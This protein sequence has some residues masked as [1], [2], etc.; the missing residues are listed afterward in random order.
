MTM[1]TNPTWH[2]GGYLVACGSKS[3]AVNVWDIRYVRMQVPQSLPAHQNRILRCAFHPIDDCL[4]T[5]STDGKLGFST[6]LRT[7]VRDAAAL[8]PL[9]H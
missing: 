3:P 9:H 1:Y 2:P 4:T 6:F 7:S 8:T 5:I